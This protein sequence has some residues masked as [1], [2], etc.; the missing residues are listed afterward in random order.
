VYNT[1]TLNQF[2]PDIIVILSM[3]YESEIRDCLS[4]LKLTS[5]IIG[6][7]GGFID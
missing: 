4:E 1:E 7:A 3:G 5:D 2:N 6:I